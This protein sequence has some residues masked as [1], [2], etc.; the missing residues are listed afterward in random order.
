V[1]VTVDRV[2]S[3]LV[4]AAWLLLAGLSPALRRAFVPCLLGALGC[5][6]LIWFGDELGEYTGPL[7]RSRAT[8]PS[9]GCAV[10]FMGWLFLAAATVGCAW[11]A[12]RGR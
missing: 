10:K 6:A 3:L 9:P 5:L 1:H 2:L 8:R 7:G 4:A 12:L 11:A